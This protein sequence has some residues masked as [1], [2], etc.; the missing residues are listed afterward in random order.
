MATVFQR[1]CEAP[2]PQHLTIDGTPLQEYGRV[3][4]VWTDVMGT[5]PL[6]G[7]TIVVPLR[8]GGLDVP[9]VPGPREF[10]VGMVL[11]GADGKDAAGHNDAWRSLARLLWKPQAPLEVRRTLVFSTGAE[12]HTC[13]ARYLDGLSP[14]YLVPGALS[15]VALRFTNLD[16]YWYGIAQTT[17]TIEGSGSIVMPGDSSTRRISITLTGGTGIQTITNT[18]TGCSLDYN[19][20]TAV[21]VV[22]DVETFTAAQGGASVI[23]N[24]AHAGDVFWMRLDPGENL[25]TVSA[26][27]AL[28]SAVPVYL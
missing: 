16:G 9:R 21:P 4:Q 18:T 19:G 8:P 2:G 7:S 13:R 5:P 26:G 17:A 10:T 12:T 11:H 14:S 25:L 23:G 15:R 6:G 3:E 22:I 24:I 20:D 27:T 1:L 28:I